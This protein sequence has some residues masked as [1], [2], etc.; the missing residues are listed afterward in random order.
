[1][2]EGKPI[3]HVVAGSEGS[4][5]TTYFENDMNRVRSS[6]SKTVYI[7]ADKV[8]SE[9]K[10]QGTRAFGAGNLIAEQ[11][12]REAI[13]DRKSVIY[14]TSFSNPRDLQ[15]VQD[16]KAAN[17]HVVITQVQVKSAELAQARVNERVKEGGRDAPAAAVRSDFDKSPT[18]VAQASK[19]ADYTFVH[20]S[21]RLNESARNVMV[22]ERGKVRSA[23]PEREMP[24]WAAK[25]Y[26]AQL[27]QHREG[28]LSAA[29][30]SFAAAVDK[31]QE[32]KPGADVKVAGHQ[33]GEFRGPIVAQTQHHVLQQTGDKEFTAHF[34]ERLAVIPQVGQDVSLKYGPERDRGKVEY[35]APPAPKAEADRK[36]ETM[37]FL[38]QP[39]ETAEKN[40]RLAVAYA[41]FDRLQEKA[42][43]A[44]P[45]TAGVAAEVDKN[46]K[47]S[48]AARLSAGHNVE[49][50]RGSVESVQYQVA[51]KSIDSALEQKQRDPSSSPRIDPEHRRIVVEKVDNVARAAEGKIAQ[52]Q[53]ESPAYKDAQRI[54]AQLAKV[55]GG[56]GES[57][58]ASREMSNIY[59][60]QQTEDAKQQV[61]QQ[62]QQGKGMER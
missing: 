29:E 25:A 6:D 59:N 12:A 26:S 9:L 57:P 34:K 17:Y 62:R 28:N 31:A 48:I 13:G 46:I 38:T 30:K 49:V 27:S 22:L 53:P 5:K 42:S 11:R 37:A 7:S 33:P 41:A 24:E 58:F 8:Q 45:R 50:S 18:L 60:K 19:H 16:A 2:S 14:E 3:F 52:I 55:D 51:S 35:M 43:D 54:A 21:S 15:L 47:V 10:E 36:A 4:G 61:Q 44:G 32:R 1:M 39:R 40:P 20:D 23:V 56:R